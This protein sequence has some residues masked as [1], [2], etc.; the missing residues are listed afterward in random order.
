MKRVPILAGVAVASLLSACA[1]EK[2]VL[3]VTS[4]SLGINVDGKPP[5]ASVGYDRTEGY[6]APL[7]PNGALPPVVASIETGGGLLSPK[8]RQLYATGAA[9]GKAADAPDVKDGPVELK[10]QVEG[11]K[12]VFFGT[13]TNIGFKIG[14]GPDNIP[15]SFNFG[16]KRKEFSYI[17]LAEVPQTTPGGEQVYVYPSVL[18]SVDTASLATAPQTANSGLTSRQFFATGQAAEALAVLNQGLFRDKTQDALSAALTPEEQ[19]QAQD[20]GHQDAETQSANVDKI[21]D[22]V[23]PGGVVDV[24]KLKAL[25]AAARTKGSVPEN[26]ENQT[27]AAEIRKAIA[28]KQAATRRLV[29]A[30]PNL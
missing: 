26:L 21:L 3:F 17:P 2:S 27:S 9:A 10:G 14:V 5:T 13:T 1:S 6:L 25:V 4:A 30:I 20:A 11:K 15:D 12:R 7:V 16:Y 29:A 23:A 24:N 28:N 19:R 22:Y 18:A 8:V